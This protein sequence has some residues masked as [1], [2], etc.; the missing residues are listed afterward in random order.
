MTIEAVY[1]N[2]VFRPLTPVQW[3]EGTPV[4]VH[5][6]QPTEAEREDLDDQIHEMLSRRYRSGYTDTAARHN[7]H[8]P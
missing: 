8:Q 1:E 3:P 2:G 6:Q 7:E 5:T 4:T